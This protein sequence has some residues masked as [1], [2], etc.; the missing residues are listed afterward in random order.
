MN[1]TGGITPAYAGTTNVKP[2]PDMLPEDHP[3]LRG[4]Y[5]SSP[6]PFASPIGSPPLT[7]EL[8]SAYPS[9]TPFFGITPAYAG[10][11]N[12]HDAVRGRVGDHP[13]L[14]GNYAI[15]GSKTAVNAGSP[16]LTRELLMPLQGRS[17]PHRI[18]P[19]YAG[20]TNRSCDNNLRFKD[21]PRLRGN[22]T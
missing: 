3:R 18:T 17:R 11:T 21:H 9:F 22:Y 13:R 12:L 20:T 1:G 5:Y 6:K 2:T 19:A 7:R 16:P 10:T 4:N 8:P 14:R 15:G